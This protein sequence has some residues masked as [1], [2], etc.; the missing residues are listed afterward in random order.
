MNYDCS[1]LLDLRNLQEQVKKAFCYQKLFWPFTV[2]ISCSSDLKIF[3]KN[4][5]S[6][7]NFKSFSRS[8][9]HFFLTVGQDNFSNKIPFLSFQV[10]RKGSTR[11]FP[12]HHPLIPVD[13]QLTGQP[14]LIG[15]TMGSC[16]YVLT[17]TERGMDQTFG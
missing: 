12:P 10:H 4:W 9:E 6:A 11:A 7:S 8:L 16:S 17:G 3:A 5:P 2:W 15:G 13:Y 14:V 1:N